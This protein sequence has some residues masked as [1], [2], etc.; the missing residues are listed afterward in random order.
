MLD[1]EMCT[2][3]GGS[4]LGLGTDCMVEGCPEV[5]WDI[6]GDGSVGVDEVLHVLSLW[7]PCP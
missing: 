5:C 7:G 1:E 3:V 2:Y 4:H 6:N